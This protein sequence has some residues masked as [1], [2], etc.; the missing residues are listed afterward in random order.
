MTDDD[1]DIRGKIKHFLRENLW[2]QTSNEDILLLCVKEYGQGCLSEILNEL[3]T[4]WNKMT[5]RNTYSDSLLF[6]KEPNNL[7]REDYRLM[8]KIK[9]IMSE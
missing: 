8:S 4:R 6:A 3:K 9:S 2:I 7:F 5:K 1:A